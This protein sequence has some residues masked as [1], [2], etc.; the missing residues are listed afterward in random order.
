MTKQFVQNPKKSRQNDIFNTRK[1]LNLAKKAH[2]EYLLKSQEKDLNN[3]IDYYGRA[4]R[5]SPHLSEPY[6]KLAYLLY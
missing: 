6:Y 3:A 5:V 1:L 2:A 4:L